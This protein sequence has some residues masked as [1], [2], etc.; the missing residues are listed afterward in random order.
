MYL[1]PVSMTVQSDYDNL[2][3][4]LYPLVSIDIHLTRLLKY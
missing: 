4:Y 3:V 2:A 1:G